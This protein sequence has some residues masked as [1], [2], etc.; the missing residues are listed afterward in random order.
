MLTIPGYFL[1]EVSPDPYGPEPATSSSAQ[2][3]STS[4]SDPTDLTGA[5]QS[6]RGIGERLP[7]SAVPTRLD[8]DDEAYA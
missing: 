2:L 4:L 8:D 5:W 3:T 1:A 7:K 6:C